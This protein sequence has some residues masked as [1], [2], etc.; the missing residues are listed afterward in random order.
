[1]IV[2]PHCKINLGLQITAKRTDGFHDLSTLFYPISLA[3]CLEIIPSANGQ[4]SFTSSGIA[5]P[6]DGL[7]NLCEKAWEQMNKQF[8]IPAVHIHLH[9]SV[10]AGAGLGGGSAD[11]AFTLNVLNNLFE[12]GIEKEKLVNIATTLGSDCAFFMEN[13]PCIASGR[14]EIL[15]PVSLSLKDYY[16]AVV[17]PPI[18]ISTKEAF[19][20]IKPRKPAYSIEEVMNEPVSAW[21]QVLSNDF[22]EGVFNLYPQAKQIKSK[23]YDLGATYASM[24]G[25]GS[26]LYGIFSEESSARDLKKHFGDCFLWTE[27]LT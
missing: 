9:K 11:A 23:L 24:S 2:F 17:V 10:P 22:E 19:A 8:A 4:M 3:D 13:K 26:A 21:K 25:S 18:H 15:K 6:D 16:L 1:M 12:T 20:A 14:G 7:P 5:L 27:R